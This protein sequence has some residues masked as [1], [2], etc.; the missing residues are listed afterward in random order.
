MPRRVVGFR[1]WQA[2]HF[3]CRPYWGCSTHSPENTACSPAVSSG[4]TPTTV[5]SLRPIRA[6]TTE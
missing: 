2:E 1:S 5:I 6:M 4:S 3:S